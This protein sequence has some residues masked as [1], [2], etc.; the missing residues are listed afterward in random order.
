MKELLAGFALAAMLAGAA[1]PAFAQDATQ[2]APQAPQQNDQQPNTD[3]ANPPQQQGPTLPKPVPR[4]PLP[5]GTLI[6]GGLAGLAAV[7]LAVGSAG[8]G[9]DS[10]SSP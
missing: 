6:I 10:P 3:G 7:G 5:D 4:R 9:S 8:G 1:G 2:A